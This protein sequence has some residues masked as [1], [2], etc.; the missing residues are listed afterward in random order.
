MAIC[1]LLICPHNSWNRGIAMN[2]LSGTRLWLRARY[3][4]RRKYMGINILTNRVL[5]DIENRVICPSPMKMPR[6]K[7]VTRTHCPLRSHKQPKFCVV[8]AAAAADLEPII[9]NTG[10][11]PCYTRPLVSVRESGPSVLRFGLRPMTISLS[12]SFLRHGHVLGNRISMQ[13]KSC[14]VRI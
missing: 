11:T 13:Y 10:K 5:P 4:P 12:T 7:A 2:W 1:H 6:A 14:V 3:A 8:S 9:G